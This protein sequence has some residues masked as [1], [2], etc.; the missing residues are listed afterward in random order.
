MTTPIRLLIA[1]DHH[2]FL[3]IATRYLCQQDGL[4]VV[5]TALDGRQA[6]A[7]ARELKPQAIL[8]DLA[9]PKLPGLEAIPLL[10]AEQPRLAII[11]FTLL[12]NVAY[13]RA[14]LA[15]GADEF[16]PKARMT[17]DLPA[18]IRR[19]VNKHL[20]HLPAAAPG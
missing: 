13:R 5:G 14:A 11:A 10:R 2:T 8:L 7:L 3:D 18:A 1:D 12:D 20:A 15:A 16:V 19:A 4:L 17:D 9:M 6:L